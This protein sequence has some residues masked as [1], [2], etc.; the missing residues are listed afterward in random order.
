MQRLKTYNNII[1]PVAEVLLVAIGGAVAY[2]VTPVADSLPSKTDVLEPT[3][4]QHILSWLPLL[5]GFLICIPQLHKDICELRSRSIYAVMPLLLALLL[6]ATTLSEGAIIDVS[7]LFLIAA[8]V[9][10]LITYFSPKLTV[11]VHRPQAYMYFFLVY[12]LFIA[13][14]YFWSDDKSYAYIIIRR[15]L[16]F[17]GMPAAFC[18]FRLEENTWENVLLCFFRCSLMFILISLVCT[19]SSAKYVSTDLT[20][21]LLPYKHNVANRCSWEWIYRWTAYQHPSYNAWVLVTGMIAA[22]HLLKKKTVGYAEVAIYIA[23]LLL[24]MLMSQSR[25]GIVIYV[26]ALLLCV[27]DFLPKNK[28]LRLAYCIILLAAGIA[29]I[30]IYRNTHTL[31]SLDSA[32]QNIFRSASSQLRQHPLLG[33]GVGDVPHALASPPHM[34]PHNQFMCDWMQGGMMELVSLVLLLAATG[35]HAIKRRNNMLLSFLIVSMVVMLIESPLTLIKGIAI[36]TCFT[37]FFAEYKTTK[38]NK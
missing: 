26:V 12:F 8:A 19:A 36:F 4:T 21:F 35:I 24:L 16:I 9:I 5:I 33:V 31:F 34:H 30:C 7:N 6:P 18:T 14:S 20:A 28:Y 11:E 2:F 23:T 27:Y 17:I 3:R 38:G 37:L 22:M 25:I 15:C 1:L 10:V 29:A 32:R 13:L